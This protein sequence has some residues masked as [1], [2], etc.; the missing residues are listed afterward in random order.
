MHSWYMV[1]DGL[2]WEVI[3][4]PKD[5]TIFPIAGPWSLSRLK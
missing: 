4:H 3:K 2:L 5:G 1:I